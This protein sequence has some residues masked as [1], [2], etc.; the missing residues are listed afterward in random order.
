[1]IDVFVDVCEPML[2]GASAHDIETRNNND[3][4]GGGIFDGTET[5]GINYGTN[6][7]SDEFWDP[8]Y[9]GLND[10]DL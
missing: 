5:P 3:K 10:G 2:S 1:M 6:P 8:G 4:N 9:D 7:N